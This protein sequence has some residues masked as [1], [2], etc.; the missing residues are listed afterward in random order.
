MLGEAP[1]LLDSSVN[2]SVNRPDWA[3]VSARID[4]T[5]TKL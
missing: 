2:T 1:V 4:D 3:G 5:S